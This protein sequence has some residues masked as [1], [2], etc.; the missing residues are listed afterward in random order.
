MDD[1]FNRMKKEA[2]RLG[3]VIE[4]FKLRERGLNLAIELDSPGAIVRIGWDIEIRTSTGLPIRTRI[5][6]IET[7]CGP[8]RNPNLL[9]VLLPRDF[10]SDIPIGSSVWHP[11]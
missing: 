4:T 10:V 8:G 1:E 5:A 6:G 7:N 11:A 2:V 9:S 3:T